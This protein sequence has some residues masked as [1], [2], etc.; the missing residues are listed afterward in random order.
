MLL[1]SGFLFYRC[2]TAAVR[3]V[4]QVQVRLG[5]QERFLLTRVDPRAGCDRL[6]AGA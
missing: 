1:V 5:G 2:G 6:A 4:P 3:A